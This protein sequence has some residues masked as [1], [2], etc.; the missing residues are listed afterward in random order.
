MLRILLI[1]ILFVIIAGYFF[2][3]WANKPENV[4]ALLQ[5]RAEE[6][7]KP[8]WIVY[9]P[10]KKNWPSGLYYQQQRLERKCHWYVQK[11]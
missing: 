6:K 1:I 9:K 7:N 3:Q 5:Q 11:P 4:A 2:V 10:L 8:I